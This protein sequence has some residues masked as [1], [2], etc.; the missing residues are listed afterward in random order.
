ML[1]LLISVLL[2]SFLL[3]LVIDPVRTATLF[4]DLTDGEPA[5]RRRCMALGA[6]SISA[7]LLFAFAVGGGALIG[8]FCVPL[9]ALEIIA[10]LLLFRSALEM[11]E[12]REKSHSHHGARPWCTLVARIAGP[13]VIAAMVVLIARSGTVAEAV[14]V[15]G[16][17]ATAMLIT[18]LCL[19]GAEWIT[20]RV[21]ELVRH[22]MPRV[23]GLLVG[24]VGVSYVLAG[25]RSVA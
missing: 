7:A 15:Y 14:S 24:Y 18:W 13:S 3:L 5:D 9:A 25:V 1:A 4:R 19:V 12:D 10:G 11:L 23:T 20:K 6:T 17:V 21:P 16:A 2:P 8:A 22:L